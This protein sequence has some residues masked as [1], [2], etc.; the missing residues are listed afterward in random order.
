MLCSTHPHPFESLRMCDTIYHVTQ[1][2]VECATLCSGVS[3]SECMCEISYV[4]QFNVQDCHQN[5]TSYMR[6]A[7]VPEYH[8]KSRLL[9][10]HNTE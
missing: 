4:E 2:E 7:Q 1:G 10:M 5:V 6:T 8:T 9:H 3:V